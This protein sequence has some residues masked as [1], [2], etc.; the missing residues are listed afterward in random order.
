MQRLLTSR[1]NQNCLSNIN[2]RDRGASRSAFCEVVFVIPC[3]RTGKPDFKSCFPV[4]SKDICAKGLS[5][6]HNEPIDADPL[7]IGLQDRTGPCFVRCTL[8]HCTSLG[9][10]FYQVGLHPEEVVSVREDELAAL[11]RHL[12]EFSQPTACAVN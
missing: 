3:G 10:G 2:P 1:I 6:I 4:V 5:L 8:E 9:F 7:V 11:K 12:S